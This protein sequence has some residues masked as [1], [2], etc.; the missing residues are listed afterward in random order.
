VELLTLAEFAQESRLPLGWAHAGVLVAIAPP[1]EA[2]RRRAVAF[3]PGQAAGVIGV[4][5]GAH[6][7][8]G[9]GLLV[10]VQ[11]RAL[12]AVA[13]VLLADLIPVGGQAFAFGQGRTAGQQQYHGRQADQRGCR[14]L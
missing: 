12:E 4:F 6:A 7:V 14:P 1:A 9:A 11:A 10:L 3:Q 13:P 2:A 8:L 5:I